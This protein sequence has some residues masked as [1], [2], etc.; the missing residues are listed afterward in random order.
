MQTS[1][2]KQHLKNAPWLVSVDSELTLNSNVDC[3]VVSPTVA[4]VTPRLRLPPVKIIQAS[5][6][7][8][9]NFN[10]VNEKA[11]ITRM[12]ETPV[13]GRLKF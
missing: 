13:G 11:A 8:D 1:R 4:P 9:L 12:N 3:H 2:A 10:W 6:S 5:T 7:V